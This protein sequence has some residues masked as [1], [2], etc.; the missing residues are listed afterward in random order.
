MI[1]VLQR[2][3]QMLLKSPREVGGVL[4]RILLDGRA[5]GLQMEVE[6]QPDEP[7]PYA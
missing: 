1:G 3:D 2:P 4:Q 5:L 6:T 7:S